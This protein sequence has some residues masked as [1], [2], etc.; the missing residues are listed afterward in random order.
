LTDEFDQWDA[1]AARMLRYVIKTRLQAFEQGTDAPYIVDGKPVI[2]T[3]SVATAL[4]RLGP[5]FNRP[6]RLNAMNTVFEAAVDEGLISPT[7]ER[8]KGY[9]VYEILGYACREISKGKHATHPHT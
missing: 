1:E 9:V 5:P 3:A 8:I 4:E 7:S 2:T 6:P